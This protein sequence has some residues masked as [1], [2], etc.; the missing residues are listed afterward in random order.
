VRARL[1]AIL[2]EAVGRRQ[3]R[4]AMSAAKSHEAEQELPE[5]VREPRNVV[6][7]AGGRYPPDYCSGRLISDFW[8]AE[9]A[10][11]NRE[12]TARGHHYQNLLVV[13]RIESKPSP[14]IQRRLFRRSPDDYQ[15]FTNDSLRMMYAAIRGTLTS[16]DLAQRQGD[17]PKFKVR[18]T[19][20]WKKHAADLEAEMLR[21]G[22]LFD[23][24]EWHA[25]QGTLPLD[26]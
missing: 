11:S 7:G 15:A 26:T 4:S 9:G 14:G 5:G 22:M 19:P 10:Q 2:P 17:E 6:G 1:T 18:Y 21:R 8:L 25:G 12:L 23:V 3:R 13:K 16:D 24:I 20:D